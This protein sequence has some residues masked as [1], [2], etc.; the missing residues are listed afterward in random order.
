V[1]FQVEI[2]YAIEHLR[3]DVISLPSGNK[4][5]KCDSTDKS[6]KADLRNYKK[7]KQFETR[8]CTGFL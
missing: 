5:D 4:C 3:T 8:E 6:A 2:E 7:A 1:F